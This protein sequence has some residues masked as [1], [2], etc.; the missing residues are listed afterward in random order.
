[1][2]IE[3]FWSS[4]SGYSWRVLLTLEAKG[5]AYDSHLLQFSQGQHRAPAYLALNPR[6]RVP[7][8]RD[9]D[10]VVYE[11]IAIMAYLDRKYPAPPLFGANAAETGR[12]WRVIS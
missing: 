6:G 7:T 10:D 2:A 9:G 5:L 12:V 4:G 8:L 11:S 3:V 1:M